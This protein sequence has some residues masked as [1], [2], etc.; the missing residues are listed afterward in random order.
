MLR[1]TLLIL[2]VALTTHSIKYEQDGNLYRI[3][4]IDLENFLKDY[5]TTLVVLHDRSKQSD[6]VLS[7]MQNLENRFLT[8]RIPVRIAKMQTRDGPRW[9]K[10]WHAH[11]LPFLRLFIGDGVYADF[12]GHP[13]FKNVHDWIM[14]I[15]DNSDRIIEITNEDQIQQFKAE[16]FAFYLR[17]PADKSAEYVEMLHRFKKLDRRLQIYYTTNPALD[18]FENYN[19]KET[20]IAFRRDFDD[21]EKVLGSEKKLN[22][23]AIQ[24]FFHS[25]RVPDSHDLTPAI[26]ERIANH[27]VRAAILFQKDYNKDQVDEFK[28]SAYRNKHTLLSVVADFNSKEGKEL[29]QIAKVKES[30]LPTIRIID[31]TDDKFRSFVVSDAT[32]EGIWSHIEKYHKNELEE[33]VGEL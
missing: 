17:F 18:V 10:M 27:K 1:N 32:K 16:P 26:Y 2:L 4:G 20:V 13:S 15:I 3:Y 24:S 23:E 25:F 5:P 30:D 9:F 11:H 31:H 29:A 12:K 14:E 33:V 7:T 6:R 8:D 22:A 19:P 28:R 21:G